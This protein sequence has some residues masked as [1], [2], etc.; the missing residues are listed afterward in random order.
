MDLS[1]A[2]RKV[3]VDLLVHGDNVPANIADNTGYTRVHIS[4][5]LSQ[6]EARGLVDGKGAGVYS[7]TLEGVAAARSIYR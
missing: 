4:N 2:E 1:P 3:L 7:L 6:L 5:T